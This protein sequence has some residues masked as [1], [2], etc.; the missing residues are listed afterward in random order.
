MSYKI[1]SRTCANAGSLGSIYENF[2]GAAL[3]DSSGGSSRHRLS[4]PTAGQIDGGRTGRGGQHLGE[5]R[6]RTGVVPCLYPHPLGDRCAI[7]ITVGFLTRPIAIALVIEFAVIV[8]HDIPNGYV[9]IKGGYEYP[10]FG[11]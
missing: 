8:Y 3:A 9:W 11:V 5:A 7:C 4:S 1:G 6:H 10:C 2:G